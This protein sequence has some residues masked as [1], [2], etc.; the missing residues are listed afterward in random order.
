MT[1]PTS[2][3]QPIQAPSASTQST[4]VPSTLTNATQLIS[5]ELSRDPNNVMTLSPHAVAALKSAHA[6]FLGDVGQESIRIARRA[7]LRTV[8]DSHVKESAARLGLQRARKSVV[9]TALNSIGGVIAG[10]GIASIYAVNFA[11]GPHSSLENITGVAMALIGGVSLAT[12]LTIS[13]L[14]H[15]D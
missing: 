1:T 4:S 11:P 3:A 15:R 8:D 12:G 13:A 5:S 2:S 14:K 7:N 6:A 10:A 9:E